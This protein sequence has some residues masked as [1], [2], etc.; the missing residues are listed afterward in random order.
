MLSFAESWEQVGDSDAS[1]L[2]GNGFSQAWNPE[3]F[4]YENLFECADFG[5]QSDSLRALF[6]RFETFDFEQ[7]MRQLI[8][9]A[10]VVETLASAASE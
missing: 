7:V 6:E 8:G 10:A 1:I 9:A 3:I 5:D 4:S 2:L